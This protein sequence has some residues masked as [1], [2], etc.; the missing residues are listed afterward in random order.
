MGLD[1][2]LVARKHVSGH[3]F[4]AHE[5]RG[6]YHAIVR[7]L[8]VGEIVSSDSPSIDVQVTCAYW[9]K[10]NAIHAWFVRECQGGEDDCRTQ[11]VTLDQLRELRDTCSRV[12]D[13]IDTRKGVIRNGA[14]WSADRAEEGWREN[15]ETGQVITD[16][17]LAEE[18]LPAQEGFFF[19]GTDYD[20]FYIRD[21][22]D[23]VRQLDRVL[24]FA[25][26]RE[27]EEG[28]WDLSGW[29]FSYRSSW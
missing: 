19:G 27:P 15:Y 3:T 20:E 25:E 8:E 10:A 23:T 21:L 24:A 26:P 11:P 9:R 22:K 7:E 4:Y 1:M 2:Y 14:V 18:L 28:V 17:E 13:S 16:P 12:L 5:E 6:H 29:S